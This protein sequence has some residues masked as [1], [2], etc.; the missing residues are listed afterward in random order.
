MWAR[1]VI[2]ASV[3]LLLVGVIPIGAPSE[4]AGRWIVPRF[5]HGVVLLPF[6]I[7]ILN[8]PNEP[9]G[10]SS[11]L[12]GI[13][14]FLGHA[15][16][17]VPI[18]PGQN[19]FSRKKQDF[20]P[21]DAGWKYWHDSYGRG[22]CRV[23]LDRIKANIGMHFQCGSAS[24]IGELDQRP[25]FFSDFKR[26]RIHPETDPGTA[27]GLHFSKLLLHFTDLIK[28]DGILLVTGVSTFENGPNSDKRRKPNTERASPINMEF[29]LIKS[30]RPLFYG[31][32]E[33]VSAL[34]LLALSLMILIKSFKRTDYLLAVGFFLGFIPFL[35]GG[36]LLL[37]VAG[38]LP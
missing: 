34:G 38:F 1:A 29:S 18:D 21:G 4:A 32:L 10:Y 25:E 7:E 27:I 5:E 17:I 26:E 2:T 12:D 30:E 3:L 35:L 37:N 6:R 23:S 13:Q 19:R 8:P 36:F 14:V 20:R 31:A 28:H 9:K 16:F 33:T 24:T 11:N 22:R 15:D